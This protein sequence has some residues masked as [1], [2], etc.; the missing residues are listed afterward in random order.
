ML[1]GFS[2]GWYV[3]FLDLGAGYMNAFSLK[4]QR[5]VHL[6]ITLFLCV[7]YASIYI[8]IHTHAICI[9]ISIHIFIFLMKQGIYNLN[10]YGG[11]NIIT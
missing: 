7:Y 4:I 1:Q 2:G 6:G 10:F 8:Y 9:C 3:L 5:A 11:N